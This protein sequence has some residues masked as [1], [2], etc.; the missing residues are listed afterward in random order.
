[1]N[2]GKA[3]EAH[4][5]LKPGYDSKHTHPQ[6]LFLLGL[7]AKKSGKLEAA[8]AYLEYALK[9]DPKA[10]R[11]KLELAVVYYQL[12]KKQEAKKLFQEVKA[13]NPPARVRKNIEKF[14][15][16]LN[17]KPPK[18]WQAS[19]S[20]GVVY[21]TNANAGPSV[22]TVTLFG[23][24]FTLSS[25][26]QS[27]SDKAVVLSADGSYT[28][29]LSNEVAWKSSIYIKKTDYAT[30]HDLDSLY[31]YA[32]TGFLW[33]PKKNVLLTLPLFGN[34]VDYGS[35]EKYYYHSIGVSPSV[36]FSLNQQ[37]SLTLN[38]S[39]SRKLYRDN[40]ERDLTAWS[41]L[42]NARVSANEIRFLS[43]W[44]LN[45]CRKLGVGLLHP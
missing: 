9:I 17:R 40:H 6:E 37:L 43:Y 30:L 45:Q 19:A 11:I 13:S 8:T 1:M 33:Q 5:L 31:A 44:R 29:P 23:L 22:D 3:K 14:L 27:T 18:N 25:D 28:L 7:T 36:R 26:A 39:L 2:D 41:S 10:S 24:P 32:S 42:A 21:D 4:L 12:Q 35:S 15:V 34:I 16:S 38:S 20:V